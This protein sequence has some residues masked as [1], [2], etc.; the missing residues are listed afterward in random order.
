M[1]L[2]IDIVSDVACP[3]CA[4]GIA[5]L[6][7]ALDNLGRPQDVVLH[8]QPFEL[9][10]DMGPEGVDAI[11]YLTQ[12]YGSTPAEQA[13]NRQRIIDRG[14]AVG[15]AFHP[16]GRGRIHNTFQAHRL[17]HWAG[18][19]PDGQAQHRLKLALLR[20]YQGRA[21]NINTHPV[22]LA[23]VAEAGLPEAEAQAVLDDATRYAHEVRERESF[24]QRA[25]IHSVPAF[26]IND[27]Y[28]ISGGQP[29]EVFEQAL[30]QIQAET[31]D[32]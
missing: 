17:L 29:P 7:R 12:K 32:A 19:L 27:Q 15:F 9:N 20:A 5:S 30:R 16:D 21:E 25:G 31:T 13:V 1:T 28:L 26:I 14:A 10:P 8:F 4:V 6:E 18:T 11:E 3:W 23:C 24:Y 2:K 22:L